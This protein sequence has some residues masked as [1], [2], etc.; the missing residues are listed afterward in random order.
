MIANN[1]F[2][3]WNSLS[4]R[5]R[6]TQARRSVGQQV[7]CASGGVGHD[8]D[9]SQSRGQMRSVWVIPEGKRISSLYSAHDMS[10]FWHKT[11]HRSCQHLA[12]NADRRKGVVQLSNIK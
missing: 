12:N 11:D 3:E 4:V 1:I 9:F 7:A 5:D 6:R 2:I 8:V 10:R